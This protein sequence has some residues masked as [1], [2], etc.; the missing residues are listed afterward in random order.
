MKKSSSPCA[1]T[2][3]G[4][5]RAGIGGP[6]G[7]ETAGAIIADNQTT[8]GTWSSD[9]GNMN[10]ERILLVAGRQIPAAMFQLVEEMD[11]PSKQGEYRASM[12]FFAKQRYSKCV[13]QPEYCPQFI[14]W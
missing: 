5:G 9:C 10:V 12:C 2:Q 8:I 3:S 11:L 7:A 6:G 4:E 1:Q 14:G 13:A